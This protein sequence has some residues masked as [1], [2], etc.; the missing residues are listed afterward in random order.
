MEVLDI[1]GWDNG[2]GYEKIITA[3]NKVK[4][5]SVIH[6]P[7][8]N[9]FLDINADTVFSKDNM[10]INYKGNDYYV[11]NKAIQQSS[12][13]GSSK[14]NNDKFKEDSELVKFLAGLELMVNNTKEIKIENLALGLPNV[15]N[16]RKLKKEIIDTYSGRKFKYSVVGRGER[17]VFIDQVV[18]F[19]QGIGAFYDEILDMQGNYVKKEMLNARYGLIDIGVKTVDVFIAEGTDVIRDTVFNMQKGVVNA[20]KQVA[21]KLGVPFNIIQENYIKGN[22]R[23]YYDGEHFIKNDCDMA[24][25]NLAH[26]IYD[27]IQINWSEHMSRVEFIL[28]C[29][30]GSVSLKEKLEDLFSK[31]IIMIDDPQF[32]NSRGYYKL[33]KMH[34]I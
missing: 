18:C 34:K 1:V 32:S 19:P 5:P 20:F 24:F 4:Y 21:A 16:F 25:K 9:N 15:S 28:L 29:G 10:L 6:Q 26:T 17:E 8:L 33:T 23:I 14:F 27:E 12:S 31:K 22:D 7:L 11:G 13:G 30:G 2:F 3:D